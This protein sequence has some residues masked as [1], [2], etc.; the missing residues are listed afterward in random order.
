L[1]GVAFSFVYGVNILKE[2]GIEVSVMRVGNDNMFQ[3][4]I[5]S[6]TIA[7][8]LNCHIEVVDTTGA[9]GAARAAG[10]GIGAY[11][12]LPEALKNI[13]PSAIYKP[14]LNHSQYER[15][16][17]HWLSCLNRILEK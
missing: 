1:E 9:Y 11:K 10:V 17:Q 14:D 4:E 12:D 6:K 16:Y 3:S 13:E 15:A 2:M 8:L 7:T 5:F